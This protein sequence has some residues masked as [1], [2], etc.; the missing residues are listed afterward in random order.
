VERHLQQHVAEFFPQRGGIAVLDRLE[1]LVGLLE[2]VRR[3]RLVGLVR[4]PWAAAGRAQSVHRRHDVE[5]PRAGRIPVAVHNFQFQGVAHVRRFR[6]DLAERAR[7]VLVAADP[8]KPSRHPGLLRGR[9]QQPCDRDRRVLR[10]NW[11]QGDARGLDRESMRMVLV[12]GEHRTGA[13][14]RPGIPGECAGCGARA[15]DEQDQPVHPVGVTGTPPELGDG[16]GELTESLSATPTTAACVK[17]HF[18]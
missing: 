5:Q 6:D 8:C 3:K 4:I 10:I 11:L 15:R 7:D 12:A 9:P 13:K 16:D 18:P 2:K 14:R 1:R 17:S